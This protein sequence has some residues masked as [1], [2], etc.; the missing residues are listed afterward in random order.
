[1]SSAPGWFGWLGAAPGIGRSLADHWLL[2]LVLTVA[3]VGLAFVLGLLIKYLRLAVNIFLDTPLPIAV[4]LQDYEPPDGEVVSFPSREGRSLR[5]MFIDRPR[6][7]PDRGTIVFCH[8]FG[9]DMF[10]AGRYAWP[11]V[12]AGYTVFTFDFRGHGRSFVPSH[13]EPRHW[14]SHLEANDILAALAYVRGRRDTNERGVGIL[15]VSRGASA[16]VCAAAVNA[17]IRCLVLDGAFSTDYSIEQLIKRWA[18]IFARVNLAKAHHPDYGCRLIRALTLFY[19]GLKSRCRFPSTLK[20]LA[21]LET[22]PALFISGGRDT[23]VRPEQTRAL[24]KVKPGTKEL[25]ICPDAKHNQAVAIDP[26]TYARRVV[27]F[28]DHHLA[29]DA[30]GASDADEVRQVAG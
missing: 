9:S 21:K 26:K 16:A 12:K 7:L 20:A 5:G 8:E 4:K 11:L 14:P 19:V 28:F 1:M 13:Y 17:D 24:H 10:S 25:W 15:G 27:A 23:Y 30:A 22:V 3:G 6:G 29:Q 2:I 18:E